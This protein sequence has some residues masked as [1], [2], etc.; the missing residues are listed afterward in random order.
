[1]SKTMFPSLRVAYLVVPAKLVDG[2]VTALATTGQY[3]PLFLQAALAEFIAQG[4]FAAHL[5]RMRRLYA[6]RQHAFV[7]MCRARLADWLTVEEADTGMQVIGRFTRPLDDGEVHKAA[8]RHG[9]DFSRLSLQYRH[10]PPEHGL[11]LGYAGVNTENARL[12]VERLR[13]A[14]MEVEKSPVRAA[15]GG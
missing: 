15:A 8:A 12:G 3:P 14:F 7:A 9:V 5:R 13:A 2:F 6:E 10:A 11:M 1:M 4:F